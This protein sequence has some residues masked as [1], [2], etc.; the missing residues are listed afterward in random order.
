MTLINQDTLRSVLKSIGDDSRASIIARARKLR[1]EIEQAYA[2][3]AYWNSINCPHK[4][5]PIDPDPDGKL[6]RIAEGIDKMLARESRGITSPV[7][8]AQPGQPKP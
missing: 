4:G 3:A 1:A 6:R 8:P 2:D 7:P 5:P